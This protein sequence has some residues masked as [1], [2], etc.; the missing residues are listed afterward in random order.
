MRLAPMIGSRFAHGPTCCVDSAGDL[1]RNRTVGLRLGKG[2][3][4]A[5]IMDTMKAVAEGVL[6]SRSAHLLAKWAPLACQHA[7]ARA[8]SSAG[9]LEDAL[10]SDCLNSGHEM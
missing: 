7:C 1:S 4:L 10:A 3:K 8:C 5:D 6:T 9:N 2:E